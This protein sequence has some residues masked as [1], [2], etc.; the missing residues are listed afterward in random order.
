MEL[1]RAIEICE[2]YGRRQGLDLLGGCQ[3][4]KASYWL[5]PAEEQEAITLFI[6]AGRQMFEPVGG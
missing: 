3:Q 5:L 1:I 6:R 4:M 2:A